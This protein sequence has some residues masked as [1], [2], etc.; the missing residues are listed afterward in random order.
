MFSPHPSTLRAACA[1]LSISPHMDISIRNSPPHSDIGSSYCPLRTLL[2]SASQFNVLNALGMSMLLTSGAIALVHPFLLLPFRPNLSQGGAIL[3]ESP[4]LKTFD[5]GP[6]HLCTG[7]WVQ[8]FD[9]NL[10]KRPAN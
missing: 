9:S 1:T 8:D 10:M 4:F 3:S 6:T 5:E 2:F 7:P